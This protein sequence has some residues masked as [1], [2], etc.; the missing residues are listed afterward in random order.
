MHDEV[1]IKIINLFITC[2]RVY[3][4]K[5]STD[6]INCATKLYVRLS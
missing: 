5:R 1:N 4:Y 2:I 3:C 6:I